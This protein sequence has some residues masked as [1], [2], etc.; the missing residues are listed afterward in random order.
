MWALTHEKVSRCASGEEGGRRGR[1]GRVI[2]L[3]GVLTDSSG[4][5]VEGPWQGQMG[6]EMMALKGLGHGP[7]TVISTCL[8]GTGTLLFISDTLWS[9]AN[10]K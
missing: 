7:G 5:Q 3:T 6:R 2:F 9:S 1:T 4:G 8:P 10:A